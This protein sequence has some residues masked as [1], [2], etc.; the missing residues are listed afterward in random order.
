MSSTNKETSRYYKHESKSEMMAFTDGYLHA[1]IVR[2]QD[3]DLEDHLAGKEL[4][5]DKVKAVDK[6]LY[7]IIVGLIDNND[8]VF[9]LANNYRE[10][11][12]E[13]LEYIKTCWDDGDPDD[14]MSNANMSYLELQTKPLKPGVSQDDVLD[15]FNQ[16]HMHRTNLLGT[17]R[18][19]TDA[20]HCGNIIDMIKY[21]D[22]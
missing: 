14:N 6:K 12:L 4:P 18:A 22:D 9:T 3:Q 10:K 15:V 13:A 16:M 17:P 20:Q 11:G 1:A 5:E 7:S 2:R 19:I 21:I 8:L